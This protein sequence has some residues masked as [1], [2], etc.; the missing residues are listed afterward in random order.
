MILVAKRWYLRLGFDERL[1][2]VLMV[3]EIDLKDEVVMD[4]VWWLE[5][6]L[7]F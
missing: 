2:M 5:Q 4:I 6:E 7:E 3:V 1:F